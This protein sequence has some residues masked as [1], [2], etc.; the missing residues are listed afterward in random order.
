MTDISKISDGTNIYDIKDTTARSGISSKANDSDVVHLNGDETIN[1]TKTFSTNIIKKSPIAYTTAPSS[2]TWDSLDFKDINGVFGARLVRNSQTD[3]TSSLSLY[4]TNPIH[5]GTTPQW[6]GMGISKDSSGNSYGFAPTVSTSDN[7]TKIATTAFVKAQGYKTTDNDTKNTAGSTD[8]SS[9][10][11]LIGATSQA[12]NPQTY[13]HDTVYVN[14]SGQLVSAT[15]STSTNS[16]VVATT[17]YV[18]SQNYLTSSNLTTV[19]VVTEKWTSGTSWYRVWSDG[20]IEQ[21]NQ[22]TVN[23]AWQQFTLKKA[24]TTT[25]YHISGSCTNSNKSSFTTS[26]TGAGD[27]CSFMGLTTTTFMVNTADDS[28][29]NNSVVRYYACGF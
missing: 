29:F 7:S 9:Q 12:A 14:T 25:N 19:Y 26:G 11:F 27:F 5:D 17:A 24:F 21:C 1:D 20:F 22:I 6:V 23:S 8:T 13:S 10:I 2:T 28:T 18:K 4:V 15:P 3:G 16:T